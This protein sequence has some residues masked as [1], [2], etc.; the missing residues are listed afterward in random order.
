METEIVPREA[1]QD[2]DDSEDILWDRDQTNR[3]HKARLTPENVPRD[4][5]RGD[6]DVKTQMDRIERIARA[7]AQHHY[8]LDDSP[9]TTP[10]GIEEVMA[11][12][13]RELNRLPRRPLDEM[14]DEEDLAEQD[15]F[16]ESRLRP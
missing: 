9:D 7:Q 4:F 14:M 11:K 6:I 13:D 16:G 12:V 10:G 15:D 1:Q 3:Q 2:R 5:E 8:D